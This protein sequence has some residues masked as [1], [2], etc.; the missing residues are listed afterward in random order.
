MPTPIIKT[1]I[2]RWPLKRSFAISRHVFTD[3]LV[4]EVTIEVDGIQGRGECEPHEFDVA[5]TRSAEAAVLALDHAAWNHLDPAALNATLPR[6]PW[7]NAIDCALWDLK[8]KREER[9]IWEVL[10]LDISAHDT[11]PVFE[12]IALDTPEKMADFARQAVGAPGLKR[13]LGSADGRDCERL[14]AVRAAA[15]GLELTI[16][17]NEGWSIDQLSDILPLARRHDVT[18]IEQ[19]V[20]AAIEVGLSSLPRLVPLCAD[21]SCLDRSSLPQLRGLYDMIN[22]KLDKTGGLTEA[23]ALQQQAGAMGFKT[24]IGCNGGSSLAQAPAVLLAPTAVMV[25]LGSHWLA[26]DHRPSLDT[27]DHR[28]GLPKAELWG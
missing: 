24:M 20:P 17:A 10:E 1:A 28:I 2:R 27:T 23:L 8:A 7:R 12:T 5:V 18:C 11:F 9:R 6:S 25:D 4:L 3:N 14:E 19:P 15:P 16:D 22:I 13:K 21:E 26:E